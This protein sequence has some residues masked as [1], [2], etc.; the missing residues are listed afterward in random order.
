[1]EPTHMGAHRWQLPQPSC[2]TACR[3]PWAAALSWAATAGVFMGFSSFQPH[4][5]LRCGFLHGCM[6]RRYAPCSG[7]GQ[8]APLWA[9]PL[10]GLQGA[11]AS[12]LELLLPSFCTDLGACRAAP[13]TFLTPFFQL[14]L[15]STF[16]PFLQFALPEHIQHCPWLNPG[17][18]EFLL[19]QLELALV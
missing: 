2:H 16:F 19:G 5:V 11:P 7:H 6:G 4:Q 17:S 12:C 15:H 14:L 13:L 9:S 10:C 3:S 8:P 18:N 1:M